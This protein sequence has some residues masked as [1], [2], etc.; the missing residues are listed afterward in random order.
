MGASRACSSYTKIEVSTQELMVASE[1]QDGTKVPSPRLDWP[2]VLVPRSQARQSDGLDQSH[3]QRPPLIAAS[4]PS[5]DVN[6]NVL[7]LRSAFRF[8]PCV[9]RVPQ[10]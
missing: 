7:R 1:S 8:G 5:P 6:D 3:A 10:P 9:Q 2:T 4:L